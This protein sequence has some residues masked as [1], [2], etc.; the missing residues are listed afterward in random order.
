MLAR[1]VPPALTERPKTGFGVP[2]SDWVR[3][4]LR[5][6]AE[7]L[8]DERRLRDEGLLKPEAVTRMWRQHLSGWRDH[9]QLLWT[10]L[11]FQAWHE[12]RAKGSSPAGA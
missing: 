10:I 8:L 6:W 2:I 3:G 5:E 7:S 11:M 4:P 12:S 9:Q 1:Y